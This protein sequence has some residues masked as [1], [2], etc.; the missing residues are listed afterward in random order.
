MYE[1]NSKIVEGPKF[2]IKGATKVD[3][4]TREKIMNPGPG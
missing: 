3:P 4:V 2:S 1:Y